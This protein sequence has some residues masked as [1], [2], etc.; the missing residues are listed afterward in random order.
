MAVHFRVQRLHAPVHHLGE[1]RDLRDVLDRNFFLPE[2]RRGAAGGNNLDAQRRE[3]ARK[4][5][6]SLFI[7]DADERPL[8]LAH[9]AQSSLGY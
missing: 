5:R 8:D 3:S 6:Q 4:R 1:S 9:A 2:Q 7:R